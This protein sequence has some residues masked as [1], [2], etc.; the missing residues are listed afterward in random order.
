MEGFNING[1]ILIGIDHGYGN[2]KT[3]HTVFKS[4][5]K[6]YPSE[7]PI[8][9][10]VLAYEGRY[11]VIGES[12]KV[13]IANKNEDDDY[14]ILTLA[15]IAKELAFR[16][17][18]TADVILAVGLPLNWMANQK[19]GFVDYLMRKKEVN[20][21]FCKENY[22]IRI[23]EVSVYPQGYAGIASS[24]SGY[25]GVHMLADIGNGTMNTLVITNGRPLSDKM[26]TDKLGVHQC[27]KR[28]YNAVQAECG[29]LPDESLIED[30]LKKGTVDTS[31][32]IL[33]VMQME[34]EKYTAGIFDKLSE[35]EYDSEMVKLHIIDGGGCLIQNFG[36]YDPNS[37]E[38]IT[39]IC[40]T[41]KG[42]ESLY[43]TQS[44]MRKG[45]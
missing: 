13:F 3:R 20:F 10:E 41:A 24:L 42:Y 26:F 16:G 1:K 4:G 22:H 5:V 6:C 19:K 25:K 38:I 33:S 18:N 15:A 39:D 14:Y 34:A 29:K 45:A 2:M 44:K 28:I 27:V 12:H 9:S 32:R 21:R 40:A 7:P 17:I 30:F 11:Y 31:N 37:V 35:Y 23:C 36:A 8:A 43:L